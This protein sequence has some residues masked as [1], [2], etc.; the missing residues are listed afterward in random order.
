MNPLNLLDNLNE[1]Q[2]QA[3]L[4]TDTALMVLAGAGSGKTRVLTRRLARLIHQGEAGV[5]EI[6][7]VTFTNKAA[8]E[9]RTRITELLRMDESVAR[10]MWIGTFHG[11]GAR[12]LRTHA[13]VLGFDP[14][15]VILD[16]GDQQRLIKRLSEQMG[17]VDPYWTY[18]R[19]ASSIGRWK[20]DGLG[21]EDLATTRL[22]SSRE[23]QRLSDF[24]AAYQDELRRMNAMDFGDLLSNCLKLWDRAPELLT[25]YQRRFRHL[26]V[27]E[28]QDANKVQY[29]WMRRLAVDGALCVVGDDDQLIY[30]WR[31]ARLDNILKFEEDFPNARVIRLEQNYRS[32]GNI[33]R[34]S[35]GLID[36]N[37]GRK[38]KTLWTSGQE[39]ALLELYVAEDGEDE[40]RYVTREIMRLVPG[41][42][43]HDMAVLVRT[44]SQ[45]RLFEQAFHEFG[46]PYRVSG[47]L[48]FMDRAEIKDAVSYLRLA[49]SM[50]DD[51][52]FDR[53]INVPSRKLGPKALEEIQRAAAGG[54]L[55]DGAR[56]VLE[57]RGLGPAALGQLQKFVDLVDRA[58]ALLEVAHPV[59]VLDRL[60]EESGYM[61]ALELEERRA[62]MRENLREL[63]VFLS[64]VDDLGAFLERAALEAD[65]PGTE[66]REDGVS[67]VVISTLHAAKGL[68][69]PVVFLVGLEEGLLPHKMAV[70]E[71]GQ[72][73]VEEERRLTYVGMTRARERLFLSHARVRRMFQRLEPVI[74]SRFLKEIPTGTIRKRETVITARRG[75]GIPR[76]RRRF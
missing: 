60:L 72:A 24:Y 22:R 34:A 15:F 7:A 40:A 51:L 3:V 4:A 23:L 67:R 64:Q 53:I 57:T 43:F 42:S 36:H 33:L 6:M 16:S 66:Q 29:D 5:G 45:T 11:M 9:M 26:L 32:S 75:V 27:D 44:S 55:M 10:R 76:P 61:E 1:P 31:G 48:R 12:F 65:P 17:F 68:E 2:Q 18:K 41:Q 38:G 39:G 47:G 37:I 14:N 69:F 71:G 59:E 13:E 56:R 63:R 28:Y 52:A 46:I 62:D 35:G 25:G 19:L 58:H 8:L 73:A 30:S 21:P 74:V 49:H 70:D 50:R 54:S 20:D